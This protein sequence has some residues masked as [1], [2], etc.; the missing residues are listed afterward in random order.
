[1]RQIG[2]IKNRD[3]AGRLADYMLTAGIETHINAD[4]DPCV[5]WVVE[6]D[7]FQTAREIF[8]QFVQNPDDEKYQDRAGRSKSIRQQKRA[9][10]EQTK[11]NMRHG[12]DVW[13]PGLSSTAKRVPITFTLIA[14]S[15]AVALWTRMGDD[16]RAGDTLSFVTIRHHVEDPT[17]DMTDPAS[18]LTDILSGQIWR[19]VTPIFL[20][21]SAM[22][23]IFNMMWL[24]Q[25]G[26]QIESRKGRTKY[27]L[28][29]LALAVFSNLTQALVAK[30]PFFGGMSGVVYGMFGFV[31]M[32]ARFDPGD[33]FYMSNNTVVL[34]MVWFG[35]CFLP[36]FPVAN[37][38][39]AGGLLLGAAMGYF[40]AIRK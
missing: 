17:W 10:S 6:E 32:K 37:G 27:I 5:I 7:R 22:H 20:H 26:S 40:S 15:I 28:M 13:K 4:D 29:V 8:E 1:M 30:Y 34:M 31:W 3:Q 9:R 19:L 36:I 18:A 2:T 24:H 38:G 23:L 33:Q 39:H 16:R 12:R 25:L 14:V 11:R 21:L 35:L